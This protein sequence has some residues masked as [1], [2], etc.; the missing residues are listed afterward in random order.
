[1][2]QSWLRVPSLEEKTIFIQAGYSFVQLKPLYF[3]ARSHAAI[4]AGIPT[5]AVFMR[6]CCVHANLQTDVC[7]PDAESASEDYCLDGR[8]RTWLLEEHLHNVIFE[9]PL[10]YLDIRFGHGEDS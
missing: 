2:V 1:M 3:F 8:A 5:R 7:S 9:S 4:S 6:F 10:L